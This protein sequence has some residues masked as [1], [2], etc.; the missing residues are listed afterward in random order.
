M[1]ELL[2]APR[3][4]NVEA[5]RLTNGDFRGLDPSRR[6]DLKLES[7]KFLVLDDLMSAGGELLDEV[8]ALKSK[9]QPVSAPKRRKLGGLKVM[10]PW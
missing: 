4:Q 7:F 5:D 1:V 10:D 3:E 2:W 6:I 9:P 8:V